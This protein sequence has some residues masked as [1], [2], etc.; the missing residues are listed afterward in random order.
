VRSAVS[1]VIFLA[2]RCRRGLRKSIRFFAGALCSGHVMV[3]KETVRRG[4]IQRGQSRIETEPRRAVG[5]QDRV[6]LAHVD[7]DVRVVLWWHMNSFTP[8][9]ISGTPRSFLNFG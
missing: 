8:I 1:S 2:S 3:G 6:R 4:G 7:V 9:Q 5:A